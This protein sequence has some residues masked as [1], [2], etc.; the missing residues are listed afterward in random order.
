MK[1]VSVRELRERIRRRTDQENSAFIDDEELLEYINSAYAEYYGLLTT[2]YEDYNVSTSDFTTIADANLYN[3]P[4][5]FFKLLGVDY[6]ADSDKPIELEPFAFSERNRQGRTVVD[7]SYRTNVKYKILGDAISFVPTPD[8]GK[9]IRLWY[10]PSAPKLLQDTQLIDG[11]NG[12][13]EMIICEVAMKIMNKQE[14]DAGPFVAAKQ[15]VMKRIREEA[16]NR[17]AGRAPKIGDTRS[18]ESVSLYPWNY[19]RD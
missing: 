11:I 15:A 16:P 5:N 18:L 7:D 14:Q 9:K 6:N 17:D 10:V 12:Y 4:S 1:T 3:L 13:E 8:A 2:V 19:G